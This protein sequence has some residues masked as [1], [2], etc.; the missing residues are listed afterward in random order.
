MTDS[1]VNLC[2]YERSHGTFAT[3]GN[4]VLFGPFVSPTGAP[5]RTYKISLKALLEIIEIAER[6]G[7]PE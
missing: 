4:R 1:Y 3:L 2:I 5:S 6:T 7:E